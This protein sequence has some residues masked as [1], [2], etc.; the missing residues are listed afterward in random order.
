MRLSACLT[1]L[2]FA[3]AASSTSAQNCCA[4]TV[5]QQGVMG[6]TATLPQTLDFALHYE[7]LR[8]RGM[9]Q[10]PDKIHDP[11]GTETDWHRVTATVS[12]G[13]TRRTSFTAIAPWV[14]KEKT[15]YLG[16]SDITVL[17]KGDGLSDVTLL[18]RY[19]LIVRDFVNYHELSIGAGI[20]VPTG[21]TDLESLGA[22]IAR[23]LQP[24]T[25]SWDFTF[26]GSYYRGYELVDFYASISTLLTGEHEGYKF[27]NRFSFLV[28]SSFHVHKRL[29][30]SAGFTGSM[31]GTDSYDGG[32]IHGTGREQ[33]WF[34]P[35]LNLGIVPALLRLQLTGE[36]PVYQHFNEAQLGSDYNLRASLSYSWFFG[37][38]ED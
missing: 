30:V 6:E 29:D 16:A 33:I 17:K 5:P 25:G 18:G 37:E 28:Q 10:G 15:R 9:Y 24:G 11:Y 38:N 7:Y 2:V 4:P 32:P 22:R 36:L 1:M 26:M 34:T 21:A 27:G 8:S 23:E 14:T 20:K 31:V 12:Y 13:L 3:L 19:S 35:G